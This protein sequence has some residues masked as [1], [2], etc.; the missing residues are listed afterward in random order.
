L[1]GRPAAT[2]DHTAI[3]LHA[4][5]EL[6]QDIEQ[7]RDNDAGGI[8]LFRS[9]FL[10]LSSDALPGEDEQYEAYRTVLAALPGQ[11]VVIRTLDLGADKMPRWEDEDLAPNPA[12][13][14][15]GLRLCLAEP[16]LFRTQLRALLRASVHGQLKLLL[17]MVT[18]VAE[19][20]QARA[21]I[22]QTRAEL[23]SEGT[24]TATDIE[25][26]GM[27][28]TPAA[29]LTV[30]SLLKH[31]DFISIGTNDLI[32]YTLA[33]DRADDKVAHLYDPLHPAVLQLIAH[34]IKTAHKAGKRVSICGEMAGDPHFTRLLLGMG[35]RSFSMH[36]SH[37]L[38]VKQVVLNSDL[39]ALQP[40]VLRMLRLH[41]ADKLR[42]QLQQLN[43]A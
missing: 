33:I 36:P 29:A 4:N 22:E 1:R 39:T 25:I 10:F 12:L 2:R 42:T 35:L 19:V 23:H 38:A 31:L 3:A 11:P 20:R 32:Q 26:G 15:T 16:Q 43:L 24:A 30:D 7:V 6:P 21:L 37:I 5:I 8:G 18:T 17:P 13:G 41:D 34:S 9:E 28:E 14:L 27:I 40:Q